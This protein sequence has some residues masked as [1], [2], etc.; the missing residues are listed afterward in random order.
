MITI[1]LIIDTDINS[2]YKHLL[3]PIKEY[4][5][6]G[7]SIELAKTPVSDRHLG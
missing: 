5:K 4:L 3:F 2:Q 1:I 6:S 7:N